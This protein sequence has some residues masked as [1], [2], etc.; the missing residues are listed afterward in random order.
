MSSIGANSGSITSDYEYKEDLNSDSDSD[1]DFS[2]EKKLKERIKKEISLHQFVATSSTEELDKITELDDAISNFI[3]N[4]AVDIDPLQNLE[5]ADDKEI[6][7]LFPN[8]E[9]NENQYEDILATL[10]ESNSGL[11]FGQV[12]EENGLVYDMQRN[13]LNLNQD[14]NI[15]RQSEPALRDDLSHMVLEIGNDFS[16]APIPTPQEGASEGELF[17]FA[18]KTINKLKQTVAFGLSSG[19]NFGIRAVIVRA[20]TEFLAGTINTDSATTQ[21]TLEVVANLIVSAFAGQIL[22]ASHTAFDNLI[23]TTVKTGLGHQE[24]MENRPEDETPADYATYKA[25]SINKLHMIFILSFMLGKGTNGLFA[26][27]TERSPLVAAG[28]DALSSGSSAALAG[29]TIEVIKDVNSNEDDGDFKPLRKLVPTEEEAS[30]GVTTHSKAKAYLDQHEKDMGSDKAIQK[31]LGGPLASMSGVIASTAVSALVG[32]LSDSQK[33]AGVASAAAGTAGFL[34]PWFKIPGFLAR[35]W[36]DVFTSPPPGDG[37]GDGLSA[38]GDDVLDI[39]AEGEGDGVPANGD[40]VIE[41]PAVGKGDVDLFSLNF[42]QDFNS[43]KVRPNSPD[44][45]IHTEGDN[46]DTEEGG[47]LLNSLDL[48]DFNSAK[49]RPNSL[50]DIRLDEF[51]MESEEE[52]SD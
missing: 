30:N 50:E 11:I 39:P 31:T 26:A 24:Y 1:S 4:S 46:S 37:D 47:L 49:V 42:L 16:I 33:A 19:I 29:L 48:Q 27:G 7:F 17:D 21:K 41:K 43:A 10:I 5:F 14:T 6:I 34:Y 15:Y 44:D 38:E 18:D 45:S 36:P 8:V 32:A 23:K 2:V 40:G 35:T 3:T 22:G 28:Y 52:K 12:T 51:Y 25:E 9:I 20:G 13:E